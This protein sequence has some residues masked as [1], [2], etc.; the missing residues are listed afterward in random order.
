MKPQVFVILELEFD[1]DFGGEESPIRQIKLIQCRNIFF[2]TIDVGKVIN[3]LFAS[4]A[5]KI[6]VPTLNYF[7]WLNPRFCGGKID[8]QKPWIKFLEN[9]IHCIKYLSKDFSL[10]GKTQ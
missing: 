8:Y 7:D 3:C 4:T 2:S 1:F 10:K 6:K 9:V 5:E